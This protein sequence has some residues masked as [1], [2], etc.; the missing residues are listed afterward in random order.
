MIKYARTLAKY[1]AGLRIDN[2]HS[3]PIHVAEHILDEARRVR[4][5]LYVVAELFT[6]SEE[7]DYVFVKRLGLSSLIREAMQ[8]W[9]TAEL[10]RLV[11]RHG[12]RPIGS[13][14][15]DEVSKSDAR[16]PSSSPTRLK[17]GDTNGNGPRSR[18]IIRAIK[19]SPVHALFMD[20][21]HDNETPAQKRDARDTLPNAALV[22][23][24]SSATG[25]VMGYDEIYP[26]LVDLVNETRLY[27]SASSGS[28][29]IKIGGGEDGIGG[30][31]K[32]LNQI[33]TLMGKDGYD[34][35]HIHHEDQYITV[36]RVHP[37]SRKGYFLIA[38]TAF[39]GYGNG[40]GDF[41]PVHL[42]GTKARHLGSWMLEVDASEE[43]TKQALSDKKYLRGL[44]S[45]VKDVPGIR[46]EVNGD[47]T[48]ITVRDRFPREASPSLR[49]GSPLPSI[50]RA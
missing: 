31:K 24:C 16:T 23:M 7:M 35:T 43:A 36:H 26:K 3:T 17:N 45:R 2:C 41:S 39:P 29:P 44:P 9:S 42:T 49:P 34:E 8:A 12:G 10:S 37:E 48:T 46:M 4:P 15:V 21:T 13:F 50:P 38:H 18:E 14:E 11:H 22:C 19:P 6:G 30:I 28:K 27:T 33:H 5:D 40:N 1:F 25:S 20:C 32:L 47:D